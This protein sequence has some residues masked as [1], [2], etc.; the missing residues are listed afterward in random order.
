MTKILLITTV[1]FSTLTAQ[2]AKHEIITTLTAS[3]IEGLMPWPE[4]ASSENIEAVYAALGGTTQGILQFVN[5]DYNIFI[6]V[7]K[8]GTNIQITDDGKSMEIYGPQSGSPTVHLHGPAAHYL[9]SLLQVAPEEFSGAS[10]KSAGNISCTEVLG[11]PRSFYNCLIKDV[12]V[13]QVSK[14]SGISIL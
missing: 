3:K 5:Q 2:A 10:V 4:N 12:G 14:T 7:S 11:G 9:Y 8:T 13:R 1:L 6:R